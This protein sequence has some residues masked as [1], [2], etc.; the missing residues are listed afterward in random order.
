MEDWKIIKNRCRAQRSAVRRAFS[1]GLGT[2]IDLEAIPE[3]VVAWRKRGAISLLPVSWP[4]L[5]RSL[6]WIQVVDVSITL[7][8]I[9]HISLIDSIMFYVDASVTNFILPTNHETVSQLT[10][11]GTQ[12]SILA[13]RLFDRFAFLI[14]CATVLAA[15]SVEFWSN[16]RCVSAIV[17]NTF[18]NRWSDVLFRLA[19]TAVGTTA[20]GYAVFISNMLGLYPDI[21]GGRITLRTIE[22]VALIATTHDAALFTAVCFLLAICSV[23]I[24]VAEKIA[25]VS[26]R[27]CGMIR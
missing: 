12:Q 3:D 11:F 2:N 9:M 21:Y 13:Y 24:G 27:L 8:A 14:V 19:A 15:H 1:G 10:K 4:L 26:R 6:F 5:L 17:F 18:G 22:G 7:L 25:G 20:L 23:A 16:P